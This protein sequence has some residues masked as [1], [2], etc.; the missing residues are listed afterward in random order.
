MKNFKKPPWLKNE[1]PF[2]DI[3]KVKS[4]LEQTDFLRSAKRP[5]QTLGM[6][7]RR[8]INISHSGKNLYK[9]L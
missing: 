2:Q 6:F 5:A 4:I 7:L 1:S 9:K 3:Q 8:D